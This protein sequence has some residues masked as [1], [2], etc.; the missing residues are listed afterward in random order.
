MTASSTSSRRVKSIQRVHFENLL[1]G[2]AACM[3]WPSQASA[4]QGLLQKYACVACHQAE[5][6]TVGPSWK[7]IRSRYGKGNRTVAQLVTVI[8]GGSTGKWGP[9]PMPPQ[10][11][12]PDADLKVIGQWLLESDK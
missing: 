2:M 11:Q 8:K 1:V 10:A 9:L 3:L 7:D 12:V 4:N 5:V 6:K